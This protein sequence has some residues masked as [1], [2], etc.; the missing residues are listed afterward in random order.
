M[1]QGFEVEPDVL[2]TSA[3]SIRSAV[4]TG[5]TQTQ[6]IAWGSSYGHD[7]L[8][9]AVV[10][11]AADVD[12]AV[13]QLGEKAEGLALGLEIVADSYRGTDSGVGNLFGVPVP[14]PGP[15]PVPPGGP[16]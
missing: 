4:E 7:G 15:S 11:F 5:S 2:D 9:A 10:T 16:R 12:Q 1:S 14:T 6:C 8:S 3:G 13:V